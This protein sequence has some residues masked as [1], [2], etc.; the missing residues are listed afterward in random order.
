VGVSLQ[1]AYEHPAWRALRKRHAG[2]ILGFLAAQFPDVGRHRLKESALIAGLENWLAG[3]RASGTI[4]DEFTART[5]QEYIKEWRDEELLYSAYGDRPDEPEYDITSAT[6]QAIR[7]AAS[8]EVRRTLGTESRLKNIVDLLEDL[9][10][11]AAETPEERLAILTKRRQEI[12]FEIERISVGGSLRADAREIRE[13]FYSI[14]SLVTAIVSDFRL[15]EEL[16]RRLSAETRARFIGWEGARGAALDHVFS[17]QD[18]LNDS[19]EGRSFS[20]FMGVIHDTGERERVDH[21]VDAITSLTELGDVKERVEL[22]RLL[23]SLTS[24]AL[25][26]QGEKRRLARELRRFIDD[27]VR[28]EGKRIRELVHETER[29][30]LQ[31]KDEWPHGALDLLEITEPRIAMGTVAGR[32]LNRIQRAVVID[33]EI[34]RGEVPAGDPL[35]NFG[36]DEVDRSEL[37]AEIKRCL[38][39]RRTLS[40]RQFVDRFPRE[41][42]LG[43]LVAIASIAASVP[44]GIVDDL[45]TEV[46]PFVTAQ[47]RTRLI[48]MPAITFY[49][50]GEL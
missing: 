2:V 11:V 19:D 14:V 31:L 8:L 25:R 26:V 50:T 5:A 27:Q 28:G 6:E 37:E 22:K 49:D 41:L 13:R 18:L 16:F 15:L 45:E 4:D 21:L 38:E 40:L 39:G 30:A 33:S 32:S 1:Q 36:G 29:L 7:F 20:A 48:E 3:L 47:N 10:Q 24:G 9:M 17:G 35:A 12:D 43:E 34:V 23:S 44:W 42:G 46:I